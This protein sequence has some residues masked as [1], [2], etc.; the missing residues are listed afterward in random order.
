MLLCNQPRC[1]CF[2]QVLGLLRSE[3]EWCDATLPEQSPALPMALLS[4]FL[5]RIDR[6]F[7]QRLAG[8]LAGGAGEWRE[9]V[10][11]LGLRRRPT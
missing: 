4:T 5:S 6:P 1:A 8:V 9:R 11:M 7:R 10:V 2:C 3:C